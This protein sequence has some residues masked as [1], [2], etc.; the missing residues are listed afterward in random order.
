MG[1]VKA[2]DLRISGE[3]VEQR[4][5]CSFDNQGRRKAGEMPDAFLPLLSLLFFLSPTAH[6]YLSLS[7]FL[8]KQK[9]FKFTICLYKFRSLK[10][11]LRMIPYF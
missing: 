11:L 1:H 6:P 9:F 4:F 5:L 3:K 10:T 8:A 7:L 2:S